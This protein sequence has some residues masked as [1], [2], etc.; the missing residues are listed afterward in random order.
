MCMG[1]RIWRRSKGD[2]W[3]WKEEVKEAVSWKKGAYR[4]ICQ[5]SIEE[6]KSKD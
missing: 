3:W 5:N 4:A 1:R 6:N 2:T